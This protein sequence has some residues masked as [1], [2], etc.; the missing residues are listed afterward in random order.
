MARYETVI[1]LEVHA[2]LLTETKIF[3]S[4]STKFGEEPNHNV[5]MICSG[6]PGVLPVLNGKVVEFAIKAGL[7]LNCRIASFSKFDRKNYFYPDLPKAYQISQYDQPICGKG[8][9]EIEVGGEKKKI[10]ITRIHMEEDA[11]KLVHAGEDLSE[12]NYSFVDLNRAGVPLLEIV[13]EPDIRSSEEARIY[14][15]ELRNILRYLGV[16]DGNL[17]EGSLRCDANISIRPI[18]TQTFG[19]K[20]EIKNMNSFRALQR[21]IDYEI[22]RQIELIESGGKVVQET[23][24]WNEALGKTISMRSKEEAHDYRYFPEPD[25]VPLIVNIDWIDRVRKVLPEL[26]NAKRLRYQEEFGLSF[27]D[28]GILVEAMEMAIFFEKTVVLGA[29]PKQVANWLMGD[30]AAYLNAN[31]LELT[32]THLT[33][34]KLH[35]LIS[36]IANGT[37]SGKIAKT[38]IEPVLTK[39]L[40][41]AQQVESMGM[42]QISDTSEIEKIVV[43]VI[44]AHPNVVEDF[45]AGKKSAAQ[46]FTGQVMKATKGRAKPDLVNKIIL[47]QLQKL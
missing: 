8:Y 32:Q 18:G 19:T 46:F 22:E 42:T 12:A 25:L 40:S 24:L 15:Q 30:I 1:G 20:A 28:A 4:C 10:G 16:C 34:Q 45:K 35:E 37:I 43:S 2:Q 13:S 6:M 33:P 5:C 29:D 14:M 31:H 38:L 9:L 47:D 41:V 23:R 27:Y 44:A 21:A 26:P 7:A 36:L 3:C 17:E 11:G 39:E